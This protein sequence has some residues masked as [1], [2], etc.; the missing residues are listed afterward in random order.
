M[1]LPSTG[2][3][4]FPSIAEER[5]LVLTESSAI[6]VG[7]IVMVSVWVAPS[8]SPSG[9]SSDPKS[10][11]GLLQAPS[12]NRVAIKENSPNRLRLFIFC[13]LEVILINEHVLSRMYGVKEFINCCERVIFFKRTEYRH[14]HLCC[15][16]FKVIWNAIMS[17]DKSI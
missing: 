3:V 15:K 9:N 12:N 5:L 2:S 4:N 7:M 1:V 16:L 10:D 17:Y 8:R 13:F 14:I 6:T 11:S